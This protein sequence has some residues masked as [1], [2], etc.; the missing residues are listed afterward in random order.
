M[1]TLRHGVKLSIELY[2]K[3]HPQHLSSSHSDVLILSNRHLCSSVVL[4]TKLGAGGEEGKMTFEEIQNM[5]ENEK[6][7]T[8]RKLD[9][10]LPRP[11]VTYQKKVRDQTIVKAAP[12]YV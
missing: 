8:F 5:L 7:G 2:L 4:K 12:R 11:W 9:I 3:Y 10:G 6:R 1:N